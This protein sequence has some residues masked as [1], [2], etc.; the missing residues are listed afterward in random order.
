MQVVLVN[1]L[2][3]S[4]SYQNLLPGRPPCSQISY[5]LSVFS[6]Q[7]KLSLMTVVL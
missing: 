2:D 4:N 6:V 5:N 3:H 7:E 1:T